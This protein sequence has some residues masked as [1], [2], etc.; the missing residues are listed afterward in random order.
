MEYSELLIAT[1][2][3]PL[4][5]ERTENEK[6]YRYTAK[7]HLPFGTINEEYSVVIH[8]AP[9]SQWGYASLYYDTHSAHIKRYICENL[10]EEPQM[11][12]TELIKLA[13]EDYY[14]L[15]RRRV[16][17]QERVRKQGDK[18]IKNAE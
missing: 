17:Y 12:V 13:E 2:C 10:I 14:H 16:E 18:A 4:I 15:L 9:T 5:W 8:K 11:S 7:T 1:G 6:E 3:K